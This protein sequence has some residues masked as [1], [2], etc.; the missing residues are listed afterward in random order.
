MEEN[1][2]SAGYGFFVL[3]LFKEMKT[4]LF[5]VMSALDKEDALKVARI[6]RAIVFG[7]AQRA[8][9][10]EVYPII[11]KQ[12]ILDEECINLILEDF[13][14]ISKACSDIDFKIESTGEMDKFRRISSAM[15]AIRFFEMMKQIG[16]EGLMN[17]FMN[18]F[19]NDSDND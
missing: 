18:E 5:D 13:E 11:E 9:A 14:I 17:K 3:R 19:D 2:L 16:G 12:G 4:P 8:K 1:A 15:Q 7:L 6:I 10:E